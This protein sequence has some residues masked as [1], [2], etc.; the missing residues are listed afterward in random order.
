M[1]DTRHE[2][3][4]SGLWQENWVCCLCVWRLMSRQNETYDVILFSSRRSWR[5]TVVFSLRPRR[6]H[7]SLSP[8][9]KQ[10]KPVFYLSWTMRC[11]DDI[12]IWEKKRQFMGAGRP[13][14]GSVSF[15]V[16]ANVFTELV[17]L[18]GSIMYPRPRFPLAVRLSERRG[19]C[20]Y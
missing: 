17:S 20:H 19:H 11:P 18:T 1:R 10:E 16:D 3:Q 6:T 14:A 12:I 4:T 13:D 9:K 15:S 8:R 7:H 5:L 2:V